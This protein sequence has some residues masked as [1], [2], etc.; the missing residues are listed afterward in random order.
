M[1]IAYARQSFER[2]RR[3]EPILIDDRELR[4]CS[5]LGCVLS[6]TSDVTARAIVRRVAAQQLR[7]AGCLASGVIFED[8]TLDGLTTAADLQIVDACAFK[9]V[10]IRGR[11]GRLL[12]THRLLSRPDNVADAFEKANRAYYKSVD[13][14]LDIS[15]AEAR[16]FELR[17]VPAH[18]IRRDPVS[19]FVFTR[20]SVLRRE[21]EQIDLRGTA[22]RTWLDD[23]LTF[24]SRD[25]VFVA[26]LLSPRRDRVL[27]ALHQ[28]RQAGVAEPD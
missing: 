11:I 28:L 12:I 14:A 24:G 9:H 21:W 27:E 10:V 13:W 23:L 22:L 5:M 2:V 20:E 15:G 3:I 1:T 16:E 26:P 7:V 8:C 6:T 17:G 18:L 25:G 4:L 19:Q